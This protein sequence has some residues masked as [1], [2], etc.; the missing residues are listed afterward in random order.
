MKKVG[1][2]KSYELT[3]GN[4]LVPINREMAITYIEKLE[5]EIALLEAQLRAVENNRRLTELW[6]KGEAEN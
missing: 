6:A 1:I 2:G 5:R 4:E 3:A